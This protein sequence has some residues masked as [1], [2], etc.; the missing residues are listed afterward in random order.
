MLDKKEARNGRRNTEMGTCG[1]I[2]WGTRIY[3]RSVWSNNER[4]RENGRKLDMISICFGRVSRE[5]IT[6]RDSQK[7]RR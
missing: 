3:A 7:D 4:G 5:E 6:T 2:E 1:W